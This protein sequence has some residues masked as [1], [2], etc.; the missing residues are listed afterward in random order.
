M[1]CCEEE[2]STLLTKCSL[3]GRGTDKPVVALAQTFGV[4]KAFI[5]DLLGNF[6]EEATKKAAELVSKKRG[7]ISMA[8]QASSEAV[9]WYR[10]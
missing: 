7:S 4:S 5:Q 8:K 3:V 6:K 9:S 2:V 1:S 10:W